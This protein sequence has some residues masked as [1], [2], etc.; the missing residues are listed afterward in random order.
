M[1]NVIV[2]PKEDIEKHIGDSALVLFNDDLEFENKTVIKSEKSVFELFKSGK[3]RE[4]F[5]NYFDADESYEEDLGFD[6]AEKIVKNNIFSKLEELEK[7]SSSLDKEFEDLVKQTGFNGEGDYEIEDV[8]EKEMFEEVISILKQTNTFSREELN[9]LISKK[10]VLYELADM[11]K[12]RLSKLEEKLKKAEEAFKN[13]KLPPKLQSKKY[14]FDEF[15]SS[16]NAIFEINEENKKIENIVIGDSLIKGKVKNSVFINCKFNNVICELEIDECE[17]EGCE[18]KNTV[19][20]KN[21]N[22]RLKGEFVS[23][24]FEKI[25]FSGEIENLQKSMFVGCKIKDFT[26]INFSLNSFIESTLENG[27]I[28]NSFFKNSFNKSDLKN[29]Y[30]DVNSKNL[31][32]ISSKVAK[33]SFKGE[34]Q[35]SRIMK[36]SVLES[37]DFSKTIFENA[38]FFESDVK[39]SK[40]VKSRMSNSLI[41]K[42]LV[43]ECDFRKAKMKKSRLEYSRFNNTLFGGS[44][45]YLSS[46]KGSVFE[47]SSLIWTNLYGV[48]MFNALFVNTLFDNA[49]LQ[50]TYIKKE[51]IKNG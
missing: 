1:C 20:K 42:S 29:I 45:F 11:K 2:C 44:D 41:N 7:I 38:T 39:R 16:N 50:K 18:F 25:E 27:K 31:T 28:Q 5:L 48:E 17:F 22:A 12:E 4:T 14:K 6:E 19:F 13:I 30:F 21:I 8:D 51:Q 49:N 40:F 23:N 3:L 33:C 43:E 46:F 26:F 35:H 37:C 24:I 15:V 36:K 34:L 47:N 9:E 32:F 10:D